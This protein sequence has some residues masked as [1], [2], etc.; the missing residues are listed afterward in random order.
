TLGRSGGIARASDSELL[1]AA[2]EARAAGIPIDV[3]PVD[4]QLQNEVQV[5]AVHA[6]AESRQ[7]QTVALRVVLR[8]TRPTPGLLYLKR[9]DQVVD[10]SPSAP[11][12][13]A[14]VSVEDWTRDEGDADASA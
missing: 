1:A 8:A 3:L 5:E 10:L 13:G 14:A 9:D 2:H 7:G 4:Y 12:D 6:P 11:S